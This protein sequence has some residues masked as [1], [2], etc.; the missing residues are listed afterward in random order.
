MLILL[1]L[2]LSSLLYKSDCVPIELIGPEG[3]LIKEVPYGESVLLKCRSNEGR[4]NFNYWMFSRGSVVIGPSNT[5]DKSKYRYEILSGNLT[6]RGVT[7]DDQ[8]L[9]SCVSREVNGGPRKG[10]SRPT[11]GD[12]GLAAG[13]RARLQRE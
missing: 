10:G 12:T 1:I 7:D 9:Y 13:V 8:G 3:L 11:E 4:Y 2:Q 5:Y 6:I